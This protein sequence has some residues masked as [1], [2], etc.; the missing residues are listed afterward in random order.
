MKCEQ[1]T[2]NLPSAAEINT[3]TLLRDA[4]E[5]LNN[6]N[7]STDNK[8]TSALLDTFMLQALTEL[9][10]Q[11]AEL[12]RVDNLSAEFCQRFTGDAFIS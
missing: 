4:N 6:N 12:C 3:A 1:V 7:D 5:V 8:I 2:A 11:L 10:H 9:R